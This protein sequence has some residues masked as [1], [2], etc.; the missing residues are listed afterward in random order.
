[1]AQPMDQNA[2]PMAQPMDPGAQP[3]A[4][5]GAFAPQAAP[6]VMG[7]APAASA[8]G[9]AGGGAG[10][11]FLGRLDSNNRFNLFDNMSAIPTSRVWASYIY[12]EGTNTNT[13][14]TPYGRTL[15][16]L[17]SPTAIAALRSAGITGDIRD[18][19]DQHAFRGGIEYAFSDDFSLA[20]QGQYVVTD[21]SQAAE[22]WTNPQIMAK[23][24]L[25]RSCYNDLIVS[26]TL[27]Y[28]PEVG[29]DK[30]VYR[31]NQARLY[32]GL[33]AYYQAS[34]DLFLSL[35]TQL[36]V[37]LEG[38]KY[39]ADW[40]IGAGYWAYRH[41][42]IDPRFNVGFA[43]GGYYGGGYGGYCNSCQQQPLLLGIVPKIELFGHHVLS[44]ATQAD[45]YG[46]SNY[47]LSQALNFAGITTTGQDIFVEEE[48]R[49]IIDLTVGS[50]FVLRDNISV[51]VGL[52]VPLSAG[53]DYARQTEFLS[54]INYGF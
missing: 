6:G 46:V 41:E 48:P 15:S 47:E 19:F 10:G 25:Y 14:L 18:D 39:A 9:G 27:G 52:S 44:D 49:H 31:D 21:D 30:L 13:I 50:T 36:N 11:G 1:M 4:D 3:Q 53:R 12:T 16:G 26:G 37:P 24:V 38:D 43:N 51:G 5:P 23:Y 8:A 7:A 42:S 40:A 22:D 34:E 54:T 33:L 28:A 45:P 29:S 20:V 2:D 17:S 32:P 35:G